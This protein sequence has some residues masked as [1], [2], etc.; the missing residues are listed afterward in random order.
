MKLERVASSNGET[1]TED[2]SSPDESEETLVSGCNSGETLQS[3][4]VHS[5]VI[6]TGSVEITDNSSE[7]SAGP[8]STEPGGDMTALRRSTRVA[9]PPARYEEQFYLVA[10]SPHFM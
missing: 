6:P 10:V 2:S 8:V 1:T 9:R 5:P 7:E 3:D 4:S